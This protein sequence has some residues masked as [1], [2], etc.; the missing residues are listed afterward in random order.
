MPMTRRP[1]PSIRATKQT[2]LLVPMSSAATIPFLALITVLTLLRLLAAR[3]VATRLA[4]WGRLRRRG[5]GSGRFGRATNRGRRRWGRRR[6]GPCADR[7]QRV[8]R[9]GTAQGDAVGQPQID[10][11]E[12]ARQQLVAA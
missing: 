7:Q 10:H 4:I 5:L 2:T 8:G 9:A 6:F 11:R 12:V 1:D 3:L